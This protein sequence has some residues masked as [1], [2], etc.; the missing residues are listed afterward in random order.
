[1]KKAENFGPESLACL[2]ALAWEGTG[3][4]YRGTEWKV[5]DLSSS[6]E[7]GGFLHFV[8]K[9]IKNGIRNETDGCNFL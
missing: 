5:A 6:C 8:R 2:R 3:R 7:M 4:A 1:M 9:Q